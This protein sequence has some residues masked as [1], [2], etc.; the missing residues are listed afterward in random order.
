MTRTILA[1]A[2]LAATAAPAAFAQDRLPPPNALPLSEILASIEAEGNVR[3]DEI[4]WE[5]R[6]YWEIEYYDDQGRRIE[7]RIDPVTG[8]S[9]R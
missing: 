9:V 8:Q 7:V 4:D 1:A 3:F 2:L 6:G 5:D